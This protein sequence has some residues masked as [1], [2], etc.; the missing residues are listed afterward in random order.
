LTQTKTDPTTAFKG[1]T[2]DL[3]ALDAFEFHHRGYPEGN[4]P[5]PPGMPE[6]GEYHYRAGGEAHIN[7][8]TGIANLQ[9]AVRENN[10]KSCK[11]FGSFVGSWSFTDAQAPMQTTLTQPTPTSRSRKSPFE[12]F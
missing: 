7:D 8:P 3:I 10:Q 1:T 9:D 6:S 2:F 5:T 12:A 4:V 11:S